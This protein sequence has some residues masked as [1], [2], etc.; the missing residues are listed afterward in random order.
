MEGDRYVNRRELLKT[1]KIS[2]NTVYA[3]IAR[4]EIDVVKTG[5][6]NMY[7]L[8]KFLRNQGITKEN[9][10]INICYCRVSS[11]KQ[12]EDL[13]RQVEMMRR[14][15]PDYEIIEDIGSG[16]NM[17]RRGLMKI[18]NLAITG[19]VGSLVVAYK[20]RLARFGFELIEEI[21]VKY[22]NSKILVLND[23]SEKTPLEEIKEDILAIMNVYTDKINGL[24]KYKKAIKK[25]IEDQMVQKT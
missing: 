21:I 4:G 19:K 24:C 18:I 13:S 8:D 22:S 20:D 9:E 16:I 17:K 2:P 3:M 12:S 10:K 25:E 11:A 7:N 1:L 15:Y 5:R 23:D 6:N 14:L